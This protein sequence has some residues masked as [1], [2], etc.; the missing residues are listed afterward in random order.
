MM[1]LPIIPNIILHPTWFLLPVFTSDVLKCS[2]DVGGHLLS[3][4][5]I[6][7]FL[8][9]LFT[10]SFGFI[11]DKGKVAVLGAALRL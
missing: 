5:G 3:V 6:G 10:A 7:G 2:A 1:I 4:T 9:A 8:A 11:F